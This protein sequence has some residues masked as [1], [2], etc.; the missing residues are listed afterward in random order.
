MKYLLLIISEGK[1]VIMVTHRTD[2]VEK[3]CTRM[4]FLKN[5]EL[6]LDEKPD[7]GFKKLYGKGEFAYNPS[8]SFEEVNKNEIS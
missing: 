4:L 3:Y 8:I 7:L 6:I 5:G 1:T 2:I